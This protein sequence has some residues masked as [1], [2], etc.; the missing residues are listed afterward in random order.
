MS[1]I[2][3]QRENTELFSIGKELN[4]LLS[5]YILRSFQCMY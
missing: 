5:I 2:E 3:F 4:K 1:H